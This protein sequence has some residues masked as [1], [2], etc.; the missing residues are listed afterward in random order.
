MRGLLDPLYQL[1]K[2]ELSSSDSSEEI[3]GGF[4]LGQFAR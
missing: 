1:V 2:K 3:V 4:G